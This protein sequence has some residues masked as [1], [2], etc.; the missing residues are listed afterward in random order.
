[1]LNSRARRGE[2]GMS[3]HLP[4]KDEIHFDALKTAEIGLKSLS[5]KDLTRL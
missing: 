2:L 4:E 5:L 3:K 1:M